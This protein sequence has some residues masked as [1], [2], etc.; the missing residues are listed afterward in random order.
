MT[1]FLRNIIPIC[2]GLLSWQF[3]VGQFIGGSADGYDEDLY[4]NSTNIYAGGNQDGYHSASLINS[5]NIYRGGAR[6]GYVKSNYENA[7][8]IFQGGQKDGYASAV[9]IVSF[10]WTGNIGEGWNVADN[11]L[12]GIIPNINSPVIIPA[13]AV[14]FPAINAGLMSIGE[15][16]SSGI[17]LCKQINI[18]SGAEMTFRVNAFLENRGD[19]EIRGTVYILN[20]AIDAVQ[21]LS[22]GTINISTGG[23]MEF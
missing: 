1:L 9:K 12:E 6:D 4:E 7:I 11:W 17:Y 21:N 19:I 2:C 10:V 13:G 22:G 20:S 3:A 14:N 18:L 8:S 16:P 15:D 23:R 5:I